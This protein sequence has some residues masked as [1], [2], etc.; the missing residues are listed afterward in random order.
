MSKAVKPVARPKRSRAEVEQEFEEIRKETAVEREQIGTKAEE[1]SKLKETEVR[2]AV[3]GLT[4]EGVVHRISNLG[5]ELGRA[6]SELSEKLVNEVST[7]N[8]VRE[9]VEL[10]RKEIQ[11]LHKIDV[12]ATA[13]DQ[14]VQDYSRQKET[15]A[16]EIAAQRAAFEEEL[17]QKER[18]RKEQEENLKKQRQRELDDYEY[19]KNLDRKK[20][21]DQYEE[22]VKSIE[23]Q[24]R[25]KQEA[26]EKSWQQREAL[27]KEKEEGYERL[28]K[29]SEQFPAQL[30][31]EADLAASQAVR[32][33]QLKFEQEIT[34]LKKEA[35]AEKRLAELQ[36]K[37]LQEEA[38]RQTAHAA[39][40]QKQADQAKQQVQEIAVRAIE[41]AS[42]AK[43]L[44]HI[45]EIAMEQ[46]RHH[47]PQS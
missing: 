15:L 44:A 10:D 7:L 34:L 8:A 27:L 4:S 6:L 42:G 36:I 43:A 19:K 13:L 11:R 25:E 29:E 47:P 33:T 45:H 17:E 12:A 21:R 38:A 40:L 2:Q 18:E 3:E 37:T 39:A 24:N 41:G 23:K 1:L 16:A 32:A 30:K 35:E 5:I 31:K 28:K 20:E 14:L 9:A 22:Q 46:A 26:L